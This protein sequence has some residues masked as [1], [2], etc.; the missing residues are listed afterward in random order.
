MNFNDVFRPDLPLSKYELIKKEQIMRLYDFSDDVSE[1]IVRFGSKMN[2]KMVSHWFVDSVATYI[3]HQEDVNEEI[4]NHLLKFYDD[5]ILSFGR[6]LP[7]PVEYTE[8]DKIRAEH[9]SLL[10]TAT[11]HIKKMQKE[12]DQLVYSGVQGYVELCIR[13]NTLYVCCDLL[14]IPVLEYC[15]ETYI[16]YKKAQEPYEEFFQYNPDNEPNPSFSEAEIRW[17][18]NKC[19]MPFPF[20]LGA[21]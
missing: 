12:L 3:S 17:F 16:P 20:A 19:P 15:K 21:I 18:N 6:I 10:D 8:F 11:R 7:E 5:Y 9:Y 2:N 13:W 4:E 14:K 1:I